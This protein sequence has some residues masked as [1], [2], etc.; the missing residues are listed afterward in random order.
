MAFF[1][2]I[3]HIVTNSFIILFIPDD[4][5]FF[6]H[7]FFIS[8]RI[9]VPLFYGVY[10]RVV[11]FQSDPLLLLTYDFLSKKN[12]FCAINFLHLTFFLPNRCLYSKNQYECLFP[13][14]ILLYIYML[15]VIKTIAL[16]TLYISGTKQIFNSFW[17]VLNMKLLLNTYGL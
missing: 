15:G 17:P 4:L 5:Y 3:S 2:H 1:W 10:L 6:N 12:V 7:K 14:W 8:S 11:S 16:T 13:K 9:R